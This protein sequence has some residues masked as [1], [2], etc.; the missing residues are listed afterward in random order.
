MQKLTYNSDRVSILNAALVG[1]EFEFYSN[2]DQEETREKMS[3][4]LGRD[5]RLETKAHS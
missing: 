3:K 2:L 1:I 5:I 4:L